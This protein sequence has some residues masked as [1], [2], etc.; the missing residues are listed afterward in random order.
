MPARLKSIFNCSMNGMCASNGCQRRPATPP[1]CAVQHNLLSVCPLK[2]CHAA[3]SYMCLRC[4][5]Q[6][7]QYGDAFV[8]IVHRMAESWRQHSME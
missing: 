6:G 7:P 1:F 5:A 4:V 3:L 2:Q 8:G